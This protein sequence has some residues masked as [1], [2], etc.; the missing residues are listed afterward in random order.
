LGLHYIVDRAMQVRHLEQA[1]RHIAQGVRHISKQERLM[2]NL[3]V[4]DTTRP[5]P[6][7][8]SKIFIPYRRRILRTGI[9][10]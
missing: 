4:A 8:Y 10:S 7:G 9:R 1:E 2:P 6:G 3:N 5:R